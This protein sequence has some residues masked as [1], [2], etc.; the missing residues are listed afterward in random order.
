MNNSHKDRVWVSDLITLGLKCLSVHPSTT[1]FSDLDEIW[2]VDRGRWLMHDGLTV[3]R[4]TWSK[5]KVT[6]LLKFR[7]LHFSR[8]FSSTIY[9]ASSGKWPRIL[10]L[11][12]NIKFDWAG[13]L[14]FVL[15]F[16]SR[17]LELGGVP[18]DSPSTK[19]FFRF[20]WNLICR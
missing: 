18:A 19:V 13:L 7:K 4:M 11:Q 2:Y 3:C 9:N 16:V 6:G 14:L 8:S 5:V 1:S 17:D 15:V 10:Q 20:H 12:H